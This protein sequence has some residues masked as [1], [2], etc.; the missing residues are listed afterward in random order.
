MSQDRVTMKYMTVWLFQLSISVNP[1]VTHVYLHIKELHESVHHMYTSTT[2][3]FTF[4]LTGRPRLRL[5]TRR[6]LY[7]NFV[8]IR[9]DL[10]INY[11]NNIKFIQC[12]VTEKVE[13]HM[14][15]YHDIDWFAQYV[16]IP[17][18]HPFAWNTVGVGNVHE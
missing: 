7:D 18:F 16:Q 12:A 9:E 6:N 15:L 1:C 4:S 10:S 8:F 13:L 2:V 5:Y 11:F 3:K 17:F 14:L